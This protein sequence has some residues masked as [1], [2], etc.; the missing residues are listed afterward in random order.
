M[1]SREWASSASASGSSLSPK[2]PGTLARRALPGLF[3]CAGL[4]LPLL[5]FDVAPQGA[6]FGVP[7]AGAAAWSEPPDDG[8]PPG[9]DGGDEGDGEEADSI[10]VLPDTTQFM[11]ADVGIKPARIDTTR[12][13]RP[14][15]GLP[16]GGL[17]P[18]VLGPPAP[19]ARELASKPA[20]R[21]VFGLHP[22]VL[23]L[24]LVA[25]HVFLIKL[26]TH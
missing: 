21:G 7:P 4:L 6:P 23:V 3:L 2:S 8:N 1:A 15:V 5:P 9:D 11:P 25:A 24:G 14:A 10:Q 19:S 16:Q 12:V 18:G 26:V 20:R 17:P 13:N 22:A